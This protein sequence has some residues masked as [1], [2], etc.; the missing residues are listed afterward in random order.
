MVDLTVSPWGNRKEG[1]A[2]LAFT[3]YLASNKITATKDL[4]QDLGITQFLAVNELKLAS[5]EL[6]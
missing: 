2:Q 6:M 3:F 1:M 5:H 4:L